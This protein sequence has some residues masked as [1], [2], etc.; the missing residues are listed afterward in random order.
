MRQALR[1]ERLTNFQCFLYF[2]GKS[3]SLMRKSRGPA[4]PHQLRRQHLTKLRS[5]LPA[6]R[7]IADTVY[8]NNRNGG[9]A[10]LR[11]RTCV[12]RNAVCGA[13]FKGL[14]LCFLY[15]K[16]NLIKTGLDTCLIRIQTRTPLSRYPP[17]DYS[18][19]RIC[20][21]FKSICITDPD[22]ALETNWFCSDF[23]CNGSTLVSSKHIHCHTA[24]F[25]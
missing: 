21:E 5:G 14:S 2:S 24:S 22:F 18:K 23:G 20:L 8:R 10:S 3:A 11:S 1:P 25:E 9:T 17:Y 16:G 6:L 7:V 12:K 19:H 13:R 15:Q 4:S